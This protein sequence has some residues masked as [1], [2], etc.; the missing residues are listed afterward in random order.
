MQGLNPITMQCT[1]ST[2]C[3]WCT[4]WDKKCNRKIG[5]EN[6]PREL[7]TNANV[8]DDA[9]APCIDCE[10]TKVDTN[11][12]AICWAHNFNLFKAKENNNVNTKI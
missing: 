3:G 7:R 2:P 12:C 4:K 8:Y 10:N 6:P 11:H 9:I 1:Y 5:C